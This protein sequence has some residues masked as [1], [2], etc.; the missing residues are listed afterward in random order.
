MLTHKGIKTKC[1]CFK[2]STGEFLD[3]SYYGILKDEWNNKY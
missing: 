3:I 2:S 1:E